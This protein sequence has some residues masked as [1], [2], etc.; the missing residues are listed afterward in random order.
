MSDADAA[1]RWMPAESRK[2]LAKAKVRARKHLFVFDPANP[3][4]SQ[5]RES[6]YEWHGRLWSPFLYCYA[7]L[8]CKIASEQFRRGL[9]REV[10]SALQAVGAHPKQYRTDEPAKLRNLQVCVESASISGSRGRR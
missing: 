7:A 5:A 9:L 10:D 8:G 6:A 3:E 4:I 1:L 2:A